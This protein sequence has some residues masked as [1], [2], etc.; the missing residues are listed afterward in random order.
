MQA[1][2]RVHYNQALEYSIEQAN[3]DGIPVIVYFGLTDDFPEANARHYHFMIEGLIEVEKKLAERKIPLIVQHISPPEGVINLSNKARMV[4]VDRG[5]LNIERKWRSRAAQNISCPLIQIETN[6]V[7]P[8]ETA[9]PKEE[10]AAH[11][12]RKKIA[13]FRTEFLNDIP[14]RKLKNPELKKIADLSSIELTP[15]KKTVENL[16][17]NSS[18][19]KT[20]HF[21]GGFT[22]AQD[23]LETFISDKLADY[24]EK[25]SDPS[26]DFLSH[27]SPYLHFGQISPVYIARKI[28]SSGK[29]GTDEF[30]EQLIVRRELSIN[31]IYYNKNYDSSLQKILPE[32]AFSTLQEHKDDPREYLYN[33]SE[34]EEAKTHDP[35]WNAAQKEMLITGKMHSYMR[36]YWGKKILEWSPSPQ[37]A[38]E[39][40]LYLN[41]KYHLDG[42]DANAF[43]GVAWCFG[44]HDRAWQERDIFGKVRY[45]NSSGLERKFPMQKYISRV[46]KL[47]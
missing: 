11:T 3:K 12:L 18:V 38:F 39:K 13:D 2:Q 8:V 15:V 34:L 42:R 37:D 26:E 24:P 9:S 28:K 5:Y 23:H 29:P 30:L 45:M 27:L 47:S 4:V 7:V 21:K 32:W 17:L 35:Y 46:N 20:S 16:N 44:K 19:K 10:Y 36:M 40:A 33:L 14:V 1:A 41:N 22:A 31:F 25:S 43:A 6:S